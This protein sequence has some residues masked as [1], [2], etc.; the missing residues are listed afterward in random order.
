MKNGFEAWLIFTKLM[1]YLRLQNFARSAIHDDPKVKF[2]SDNLAV[3]TGA[4]TRYKTDNTE[5]ES[6]DFTYTMRNVSVRSLSMQL[7]ITDLSLLA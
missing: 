1:A 6:F 3:I 5:L 2:L 4:A 7:Y